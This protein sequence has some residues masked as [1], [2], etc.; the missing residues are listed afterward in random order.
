MISFPHA[1]H[2][3][4]INKHGGVESWG[5]E[6]ETEPQKTT[7]IVLPRLERKILAFYT[8]LCFLLSLS[9]FDPEI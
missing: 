5:S 4:S 2:T 8:V 9:R 1:V 7:Q 3:E 6:K